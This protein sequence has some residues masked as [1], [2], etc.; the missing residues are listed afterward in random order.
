MHKHFSARE[1]KMANV[2]LHQNFKLLR[3]DF[4][5]TDLDLYIIKMGLV[6]KR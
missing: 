2:L 6:I 1:K 3:H 5:V 4:I